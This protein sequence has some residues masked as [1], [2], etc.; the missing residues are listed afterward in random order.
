MYSYVSVYIL[1]M[2]FP[3]AFGNVS[4]QRVMPKR[5]EAMDYGLLNGLHLVGKQGTR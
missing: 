3:K 1:Y 5:E 2:G 4:H